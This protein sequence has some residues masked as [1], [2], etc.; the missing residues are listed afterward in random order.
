MMNFEEKEIIPE[1]LMETEKDSTEMAPEEIDHALNMNHQTLLDGQIVDMDGVPVKMVKD[2]TMDVLVQDVGLIQGEGTIETDQGSM[3]EVTGQDSMIE[4]IEDQGS[5][6][7]VTGQGSMIEDQGQM[8]VDQGQMIM[9]QGQMIVDQG[10]M[11]V[12]QGQMIEEIEDQKEEDMED[13]DVIDL[14][15]MMIEIVL[16]EGDLMIEEEVM[17]KIEDLTETGLII[18]TDTM[19]E[20]KDTTIDKK[21]FHLMG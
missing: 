2:V 14:D 19:K 21:V 5:M 16:D 15:L 6:I 10:Q 1:N 9:D 20:A 4:E 17:E 18:E 8:I 11:I 12:D 7:E 13:L 3:I